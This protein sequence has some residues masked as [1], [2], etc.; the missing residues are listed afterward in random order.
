VQAISKSPGCFTYCERDFVPGLLCFGGLFLLTSDQCYV[1][2]GICSCASGRSPTVAR[3]PGTLSYNIA[4]Y[5]RPSWVGW[6][7]LSC[8]RPVDGRIAHSLSSGQKLWWSVCL[9]CARS[10]I[11]IPTLP[12]GDFATVELGSF[13]FLFARIGHLHYNPRSRSDVGQP[14]AG[15]RASVP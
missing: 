7:A 14:R 13:L 10:G 4:S 3:R 5:W 8:L 1:K 2:S 12:G 9:A 11:E 6:Q 15:Y